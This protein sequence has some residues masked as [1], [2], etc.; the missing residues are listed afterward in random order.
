MYVIAHTIHA[1]SCSILCTVCII[2]V[3]IY[4]SHY[5]HDMQSIEAR[6]VGDINIAW[7]GIDEEVFVF[8]ML[9][10]LRWMCL[11]AM[12]RY[13]SFRCSVRLSGRFSET[14][15]TGEYRVCACYLLCIRVVSDRAR[16]LFSTLAETH[17]NFD[18]LPQIGIPTVTTR[19]HEHTHTHT[20]YDILH[21]SKL[22]WIF[23]GL[24]M[25]TNYGVSSHQNL[26]TLTYR[27]AVPSSRKDSGKQPKLF[28]LGSIDPFWKWETQTKKTRCIQTG[29]TARI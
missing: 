20:F 18:R 11:C 19:A 9:H 28:E 1:C 17:T 25:A 23:R 26:K 2:Y 4:T 15:W 22:W 5:M 13:F 16:L 27:R 3:Q 6:N 10:F 24:Q 7:F 14:I 21:E 29:G 12:S 8:P